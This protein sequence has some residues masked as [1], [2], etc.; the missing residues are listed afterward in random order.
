MVVPWLLRTL[1]MFT[2][3]YWK[4]SIFLFIL[5][6]EEESVS[7]YCGTPALRRVEKFP[8]P[9]EAHIFAYTADKVP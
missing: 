4:L 3:L 1:N 8:G 6:I 2:Q 5:D 9:N 7:C